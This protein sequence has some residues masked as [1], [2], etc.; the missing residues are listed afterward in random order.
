MSTSWTARVWT[1]ARHVADN[2][3]FFA[4]PLPGQGR[5]PGGAEDFG[6]V[7]VDTELVQDIPPRDAG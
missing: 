6:P 7:G 5:Q 4:E 1:S 3:R 2:I